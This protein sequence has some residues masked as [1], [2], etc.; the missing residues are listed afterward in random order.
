[1]KTALLV[2]SF[3]TVYP[4]V[5]ESAVAPVEAVLSAAF[6]RFPCYRAFTGR[7]VR[8]LLMRK[9]RIEVDD[10]PTALDRIRSDGFSHVVI[11]PTLLIPGEE[12]AGLLNTVQSSSAGLTVSVGAPLLHSDADLERIIAVI[13]D[14]Y[15]LP[16]NS[17]M[18]LL[19]HGS[20]TDTFGIY[21]RLACKLRPTSVRLCTMQGSPSFSDGIQAIQ[22][23]GVN[24]VFLVPL[25]LCAGSHARE[26]L[27]EYR[28]GSLLLMLKEAG[29][30]ATPIL[31]GLGELKDVQQLYADKARTAYETLLTL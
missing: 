6:P 31:R 5:L 4:E 22:E 16:E 21:Q 24:R 19:G 28:T 12:Y 15:P 10:V 29:I 30:H 17:A 7:R 13:Q 1:M 27:T 14:T 20:Q 2:V 8:S 23:L 18:L 3:G 25:L 11:Q 9:Y 26:H